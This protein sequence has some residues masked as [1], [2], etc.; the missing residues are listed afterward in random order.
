[1]KIRAI[2]TA[3]LFVPLLASAEGNQ[4]PEQDSKDIRQLFAGM[5]EAWRAGDDPS[6]SPISRNRSAS[7]DTVIP[8][9]LPPHTASF[10]QRTSAG[11]KGAQGSRAARPLRQQAAV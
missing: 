11:H 10:L 6:A 5:T 3:R 8:V 7:I 4:S 1:M 2:L 9:P